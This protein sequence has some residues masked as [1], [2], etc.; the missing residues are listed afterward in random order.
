MAAAAGIGMGLFVLG[1]AGYQPNMEQ[2]PQ[3]VLTLR[4]LYALVPSVCNLVAIC[5]ALAYP[6]TGE[7]HS[8]IQSAID[9]RKNGQAVRDPLQ[10]EMIRA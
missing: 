5:I 2:S 10:P 4:I 7:V 9:R 3:V 1:L 6:I 8:Q